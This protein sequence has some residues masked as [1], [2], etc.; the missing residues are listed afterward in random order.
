MSVIARGLLYRY[1]DKTNMT[2]LHLILTFIILWVLTTIF[3][4]LF[5]ALFQIPAM[6]IGIIIKSK[7]EEKIKSKSLSITLN[8]SYNGSVKK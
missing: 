3:S 5:T 6:R 7:Y 8:S 2:N 4:I 1:N